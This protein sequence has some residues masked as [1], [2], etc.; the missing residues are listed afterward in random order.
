MAL[1]Q[2]SIS[3]MTLKCQILLD[4]FIVTKFDTE[5]AYGKKMWQKDAKKFWPST[6]GYR[7]IWKSKSDI[8]M[9]ITIK[10]RKLRVISKNNLHDVKVTHD[11]EM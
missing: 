6:T 5:S 8:F 10:G 2:I 1:G 9:F 7:T 3:L 4:C 11:L